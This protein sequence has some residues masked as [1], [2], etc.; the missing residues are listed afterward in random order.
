MTCTL[1]TIGSSPVTITLP[2]DTTWQTEFARKFVKQTCVQRADGGLFVMEQ[3]V[4]AGQ[5]ITVDPHFLTYATCQAINAIMTAGMTMTLTL[6]GGQVFT[7]IWD[8]AQQKPLAT[9]PIADY[10]DPVATTP[11]AVLLYFL[12]L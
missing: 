6:P 5:P 4:T 7:V 8:Y 11:Y 9:T 3:P 2:P 12:Q 1:V 10:A